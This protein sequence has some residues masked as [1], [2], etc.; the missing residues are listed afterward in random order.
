MDTRLCQLCILLHFDCFR[1]QARAEHEP[2]FSRRPSH[3]SVKQHNMTHAFANGHLLGPNY[4]LQ[5]CFPATLQVDVTSVLGSFSPGLAKTK[6][7]AAICFKHSSLACLLSCIVDSR[8]ISIL[9]KSLFDSLAFEECFP[10]LKEVCVPFTI[11]AL[12]HYCTSSFDK[13]PFQTKRRVCIS[14]ESNCFSSTITPVFGHPI[15][16]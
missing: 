1:G 14:H 5:P 4:F 10:Y 16:I 9:F 3:L 7:H 11:L 13:Q 8:W 2:L 6:W 15:K 12:R